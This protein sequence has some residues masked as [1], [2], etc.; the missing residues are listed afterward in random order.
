MCVCVH[1]RVCVRA[2]VHVCAC[3]CACVRACTC[4]CV[5]VCVSAFVCVCACVCACVRAVSRPGVKEGTPLKGS[6]GPLGK[7]R[8]TEESKSS[9]AAPVPTACPSSFSHRQISR[10]DVEPI[11]FLNLS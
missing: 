3:V 10:F 7:H 9:V 5:C 11:C 8:G 2:C 4:V 6:E 1:V